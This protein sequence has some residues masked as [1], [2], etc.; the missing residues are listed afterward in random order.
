MKKITKKKHLEMKLQSIPPHPNP[1][2]GLEQYT[3]P[4]I[5]A[6][7]LI[8]NANS[9]GDIEN[10]NILDLGCGSGIFTIASVLL[11]ANFACGV[12]VDEDSIKLAREM[13]QKL[14]LDKTDYV[15]S[16]I[17]DFDN[18]FKADTIIQNP[19]FG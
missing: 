8:W 3:T 17:C 11:G 16:D 1:K 5:I 12:D 10:K 2:V 13:S 9:L 15:L 14:K 18:S 6:A 4:A 19:P 7:D